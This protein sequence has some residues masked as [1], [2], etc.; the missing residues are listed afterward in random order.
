MLREKVQKDEDEEEEPTTS[1][2]CC[3]RNKQYQLAKTNQTFHI[4]RV[5][6]VCMSVYGPQCNNQKILIHAH[7][8]GAGGHASSKFNVRDCT[9]LLKVDRVIAFTTIGVYSIVNS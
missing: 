8:K 9:K 5:F 3:R 7:L 6:W 2:S 1:C 4:K